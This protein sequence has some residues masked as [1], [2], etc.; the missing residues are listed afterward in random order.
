MSAVF[1]HVSDIHFG[2]ERGGAVFIHDDVK[3]RVIDDA[4]REI[5]R[6]P[7]KQATGVLVTGDIAYAGKRQQYQAAGAWL[8]ALAKAVRCKK[9]DVYVVPGNH[10][11][12]QDEIG[13]GMEHMLNR[14]F[15]EGEETLDKITGKDGDRELFYRRFIEYR[16]FA[17]GYNCP[18]DNAGT[19]P[20][21]RPFELAPD[22]NIRIVG[23]NSALIC[24]KKRE[25]KGQ[26][27]LGARQR[28]LPVNPSEELIVMAHHPLDWLKDSEDAKRYLRSRARVFISGHEHEPRVIVEAVKPGCDLMML[29]SGAMVPPTVS[30]KYNYT[31]NIIVFDW[32]TAE[33]ALAVTVHPRAWHD[34]DKDFVQASEQLDGKGPRFVLACPRYSARATRSGAEAIAVV[35]G[36]VAPE[37]PITLATEEGMSDEYRLLL[38]RY[39]RD[40]LPGQRLKVLA[41]LKVIPDDWSDELSHVMERR[42]VDKIA[43]D[44]R[45]EELR[46]A[47]DELAGDKNGSGGTP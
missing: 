41:Q 28:V 4:A 40:L 44:G 27:L 45:L 11:I 46:K 34:E 33:D 2:Q 36:P 18:L 24:T 42:I 37:A 8:D 7:G 39:F 13:M 38:L 31:Y 43:A 14:V 47:M 30:D 20:A 6:L 25:E 15:D 1:V 29:A 32:D 12:D 26:L 10:D 19:I 17:E 9:T 16:P 22:R 35:S 5:E 3:A 21:S 23:F